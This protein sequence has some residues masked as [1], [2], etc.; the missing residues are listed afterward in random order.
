MHAVGADDKPGPRRRRRFELEFDA[1]CIL[2]KPNELVFTM[3]G[4]GLLL[5]E[6]LGDDAM[7][8]AAVNGDVGRALALDRLHA[9]IE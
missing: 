3:N 4:I 5:L 6:R 8:V 9:E 7:Q 1:V 2:P